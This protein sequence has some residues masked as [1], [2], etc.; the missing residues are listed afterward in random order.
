VL[1]K[2]SAS[3]FQ[4]TN[5][6]RSETFGLEAR[7]KRT[8]VQTHKRFL[9]EKFTSIGFA[10]SSWEYGQWTYLIELGGSQES[11]EAIFGYENTNLTDRCQRLESRCS[12]FNQMT[13]FMLRQHAWEVTDRVIHRKCEWN[14][15]DWYDHSLE[16]DS[17][18]RKAG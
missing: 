7:K 1:I 8:D 13:L 10:L 15:P 17:Q 12:L 4:S 9:R 14:M 2:R 6:C 5:K 18:P 11:Q 16:A 3:R